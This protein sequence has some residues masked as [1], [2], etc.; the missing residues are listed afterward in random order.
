MALAPDRSE[1]K[2]EFKRLET[3]SRKLSIRN[4]MRVAKLTDSN[5]VRALK[6]KY[7]FKWFSELSSSSLVM[8]R[9]GDDPE[10]PR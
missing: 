2:D 9:R 6:K 3:D 7:N 10:K 1:Y 5:L 4:D 8:F